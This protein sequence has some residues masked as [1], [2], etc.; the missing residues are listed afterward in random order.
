[1]QKKKKISNTLVWSDR[2][3]PERYSIY[4]KNMLLDHANDII[5][6][7]KKTVQLILNVNR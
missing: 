2:F 4:P 6:I 7:K 5:S 3:K 1:M